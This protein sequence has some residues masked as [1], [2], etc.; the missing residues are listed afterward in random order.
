MPE[1]PDKPKIIVDEDWK[2][3]VETEREATRHRAAT[4][5]ACARS[6]AERYAPGRHVVGLAPYQPSQL[7][8]SYFPHKRQL[9][10]EQIAQW[11][12][13]T[14]T[15]FQG[16]AEFAYALLLLC[17]EASLLRYSNDHFDVAWYPAGFSIVEQGERAESLYLLLSGM[18]QVAREGTHQAHR[19]LAHQRLAARDAK[20]AH[21]LGDERRTQPVEFL[22]RQQIGLRQERHVFRHA[23]DTAEIA[24]IGDRYAQVRDGALEWVDQ[25]TRLLPRAIDFNCRGADHY[26]HPLPASRI[27]GTQPYI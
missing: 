24:S 21:A 9:L 15:P 5:A 13:Q 22:E 25:S 7:L 12:V 20:L 23:V 1:T 26:C 3:Q 14:K 4:T 6:G 2:S 11:L 16:T 19:V 27:P 10:L 17:E 18:A 8:Y